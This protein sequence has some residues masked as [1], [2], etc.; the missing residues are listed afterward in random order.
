MARKFRTFPQKCY[1]HILQN[2]KGKFSVTQ[3]MKAYGGV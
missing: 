1:I 3:T 2:K